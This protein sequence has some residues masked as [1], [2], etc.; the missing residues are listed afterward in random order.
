MTALDHLDT[1][2][3]IAGLNVARVPGWQTRRRPGPFMPLGVLLHDTVGAKTGDAPSLDVVINGRPDLNGPLYQVLIARSGRIHLVAAGR[4]NNAGEGGPIGPIPGDTGNRHLVGIGFE[5][6]GGIIE[7]PYTPAQ[8]DVGPIVCAAVLDLIGA[9]RSRCWGHKEYAPGRK[10]DPWALDMNNWRFV[11]AATQI[12]QP[13]MPTYEQR[14]ATAAL[15]LQ[16]LLL[17]HQVDLG[18]TGPTNDG[19]D[20]DPGPRTLNGAVTVI[21][22]LETQLAELGDTIDDAVQADAEKWRAI[23]QHL[24]A[25]K[26]ET[27]DLAG[28]VATITGIVER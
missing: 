27:T 22:R 9:P 28:T 15:K 16:T 8:L 14:I 17:A 1:A 13:T 6:A 19:R 12:G 4:T 25:L 26:A 18:T 24:T 21:E 3:F 11:V 5:N 2:L 10:I 7:Q 20:S 23:S